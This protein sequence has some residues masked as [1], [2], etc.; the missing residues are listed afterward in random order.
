ML[1]TATGPDSVRF[2]IWAYSNLRTGI[3][4]GLSD[5]FAIDIDGPVSRQK[6]SANSLVHPCKRI[7][8]VC[9]KNVKQ[10]G[11]CEVLV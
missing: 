10:V 2:H 5:G 1:K 6:R 11:K 7:S 8:G 9:A 4:K 3:I